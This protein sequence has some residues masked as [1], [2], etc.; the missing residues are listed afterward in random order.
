[1]PLSEVSSN[2]INVDSYC[3]EA[4]SPRAA[5]FDSL[6]F[7]PKD[8]SVVFGYRADTQIQIA[9]LRLVVEVARE[10]RV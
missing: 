8:K 9:R 5:R 10:V 3:L 4:D 7:A 6:E 2:R 1:M